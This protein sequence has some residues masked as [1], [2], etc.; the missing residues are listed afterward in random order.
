MFGRTGAFGNSHVVGGPTNLAAG[1]NFRNASIS[2][3]E[4]GFKAEFRCRASLR[5]T[6]R[7]CSKLAT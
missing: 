4:H 7:F 1:I 5:Q 2:K 6:D 3:T